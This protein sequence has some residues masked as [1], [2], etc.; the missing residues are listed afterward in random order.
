MAKHISKNWVLSDVNSSPD[1]NKCLGWEELFGWEFFGSHYQES[2]LSWP[3]VMGDFAFI[4]WKQTKNNEDFKRT[5]MLL[6]PF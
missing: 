5:I 2:I 3:Q 6:T 1:Y 4:T